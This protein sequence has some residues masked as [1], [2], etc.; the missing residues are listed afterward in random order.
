MNSIIALHIWN[1]CYN[2]WSYKPIP[3]VVTLNNSCTMMQM[4]NLLDGL[5][6]KLKKNDS[7]LYPFLALIIST[8][9]QIIMN[10]FCSRLKMRIIW[11]FISL[12]PDAVV[13]KWN[14]KFD[15]IT[16]HK[17]NIYF[18]LKLKETNSLVGQTKFAA[19]IALDNVHLSTN[20][21]LSSSNASKIS[22]NIWYQLSINIRFNSSNAPKISQNR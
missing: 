20:I 8:N 15:A 10:E 12:K 2:T 21:R 3:T 9:S 4:R 7:S 17:Q 11:C 5:T 13:L 16:I 19:Y 6:N 1:L 14:F 22:Q 18:A